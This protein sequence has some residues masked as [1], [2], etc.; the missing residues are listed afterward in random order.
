MLRRSVL[1]SLKTGQP[2]LEVT[3]E[4]D[5]DSNYTPKECATYQKIKAYVKE[6]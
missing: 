5:A 3:M 1:L 2:K 6:K 4:V